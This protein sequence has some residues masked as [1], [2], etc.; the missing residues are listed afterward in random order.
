MSRKIPT[1]G[2][3]RFWW[4]WGWRSWRPVIRG[5]DEFCNRTL[6]L[7]I[8]PPW[9]ALV[10]VTGRRLRNTPCDECCTTFPGIRKAASGIHRT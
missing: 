2:P 10:V 5:A 4:S 8:L 6:V 1:Y 9:G 7:R 3:Q